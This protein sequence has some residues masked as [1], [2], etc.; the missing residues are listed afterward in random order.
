MLTYDIS[1]GKEILHGS[2]QKRYHSRGNIAET[3][4]CSRGITAESVPTPTIT[5]VFRPM[6]SPLLLYSHGYRGITAIPIPMQPYSL[7]ISTGAV[8]CR[9]E[10]AC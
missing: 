5:A 1:H 4:P 10:M 3:R 7:G 9:D 6:L 8:D 2:H